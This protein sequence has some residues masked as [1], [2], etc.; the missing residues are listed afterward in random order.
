MSGPS[1]VP[2]PVSLSPDALLSDA[3]LSIPPPAVG[4]VSRARLIET[5]CT[6]RRRVVAVVAPAGYGT[7]IMVEDAEARGVL[8]TGKP[9]VEASSGNTATA[10]AVIGP[11][12]GY[13][14]VVVA[15]SDLPDL[16]KA[17]LETLG[18]ELVLTDPA[19]RMSGAIA[20]ALPVVDAMASAAYSAC[21][22]ASSAGARSPRCSTIR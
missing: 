4:F 9:I 3:K 17:N 12:K 10:L 22:R 7:V 20:R 13:K 6:A 15:P 19:E 11:A 16:R 14:V 2:A 8:S 5:A 18:V 21:R 1:A